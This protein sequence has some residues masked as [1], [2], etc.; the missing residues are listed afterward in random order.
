MSK[1]NVAAR[2]R[3]VF[4]SVAAGMGP[5]RHLGAPV[6]DAFF[7]H[8]DDG[9]VEHPLARLMSSRGGKAGGGRGGKTR[10]LLYL[11][12]LWVAAGGDHSS[13]R[14]ARFWAEL[15]GLSDP[16]GAGSRV[17]RSSWRELAARNF[18]K[19]TKE[20][21]EGAV[22]RVQLLREDGSGKPYTIPNGQG[23]DTYRR[24]PEQA[25]RTL[26]PDESLSGP[27]LV[28]YLIALRT[29]QRAQTIQ[30]LTF[31]GTYITTEYGIG[32]ST[33]KS[34]LRDLSKAAVLD[35][36]RRPVDDVGG[37]SHRVRWRYTYD[38]NDLYAPILKPVGGQ[39]APREKET[40]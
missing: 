37:T 31:P 12:L 5:R 1:K 8:E 21:H 6:R 16:D 27:G 22:P 4:A 28:M 35:R 23:G 7:R 20:G 19:M 2:Q 18:V 26:F 11:S 36:D 29:A 10:V 34:G 24:I 38:L 40:R 17:I 15:L 30:G 32:E 3:E 13:D 39:P 14:P 25:W 33:R 9:E